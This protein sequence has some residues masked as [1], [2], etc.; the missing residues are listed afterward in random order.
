MY[1]FAAYNI[2]FLLLTDRLEQCAQHHDSD[3]SV[4]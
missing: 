1:P 2:R 4:S 3:D